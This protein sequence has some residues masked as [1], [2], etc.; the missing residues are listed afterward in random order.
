MQRVR[1]TVNYNL[2]QRLGLTGNGIHVAILDSGVGNHPDLTGRVI[3]NIDF[4]HN[5]QTAYDDCGHGTHIAGI[6]CG[7]GN[8]SRGIFQ[9]IAPSCHIISLKVLDEAG[10][11]DVEHL[12]KGIRWVIQNQKKYNIR[13]M[14]ISIGSGDDLGGQKIRNIIEAVEEAWRAGL[15]VVAAAGNGGPSTGSISVIGSSS[16]VIT[17]GCHDNGYT[18][19][20][21]KSC[22]Q[23]SGRGPSQYAIKKPDIVAPGTDIVSCNAFTYHKGG[24]YVY[25][26]VK[27]SGTSM[28]TPIVSGACALLL[29][30]EPRLTNDEVK[31]RMQRTATDL[32]ENWTK[33]G[34]GM[35]NV[36]RLL[37]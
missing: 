3:A 22:E 1:D 6:L 19:S 15:V 23:Y 36:G 2:A 17:V 35:L 10:N 16:R 20:R 29:E 7:S 8:L 9:G 5:K 12:I 32:H 13:I 33:Q 14:N 28:A 27:K 4:L 30:K 11:G 18:D 31:I 34:W 37:S 26:Y 24:R 25:P 21:G